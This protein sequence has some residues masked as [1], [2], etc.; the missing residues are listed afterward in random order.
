[1]LGSF[2]AQSITVFPGTISALWPFSQGQGSEKTTFS[3]HFSTSKNHKKFPKRKA[4]MELGE[5]DVHHLEKVFQKKFFDVTFPVQLWAFYGFWREIRGQK[6]VGKGFL[7][8]KE[9]DHAAGNFLS[10]KTNPVKI[11]CF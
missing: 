11:G 1:M 8:L 6:L 2:E 10:N 3:D 9:Q 7:I 4:D 5:R